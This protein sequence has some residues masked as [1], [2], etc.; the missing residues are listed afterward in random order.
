[1]KLKRKAVKKILS[2]FTKNYTTEHNQNRPP[3]L[4]GLFKILLKD[5]D[6][7][8]HSTFQKPRTFKIPFWSNFAQELQYLPLEAS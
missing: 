8:I 3:I 5:I 7:P 4:G 1:M 6:F 2:I